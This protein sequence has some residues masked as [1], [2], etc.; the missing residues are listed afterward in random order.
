M[1]FFILSSHHCVWCGFDPRLGVISV[2]FWRVLPLLPNQLIGLSHMSW[3]N[4]ERDIKL[5]NYWNLLVR[6]P[7]LWVSEKFK[8]TKVLILKCF[9][10]W[11]SP[12]N[13]IHF[14]PSLFKT[15]RGNLF[16]DSANQVEKK[17]W[18]KTSHTCYNM[19]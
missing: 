15:I 13:I 9:H 18:H 8:A 19:H 1:N 2:F 7:D 3:N 14:W 17:V 16:Y 12:L 10:F 4:L 6:T 5:N 11:P